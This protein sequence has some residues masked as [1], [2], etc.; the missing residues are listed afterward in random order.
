MNSVVSMSRGLVK[1]VLISS[2]TL[3]VRD[4]IFDGESKG[5]T[6]MK[7]VIFIA[8]IVAVHIFML[9]V[10][11]IYGVLALISLVRHGI[12]NFIGELRIFI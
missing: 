1:V 4:S 11:S 6:Y 2:I 12:S 10:H 7:Q 5:G 3:I 9:G 8:V